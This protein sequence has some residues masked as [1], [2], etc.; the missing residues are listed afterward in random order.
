[1]KFVD[2]KNVYMNMSSM[3]NIFPRGDY[4]SN[5]TIYTGTDTDKKFA[6]QLT[7]IGN[8]ISNYIHTFG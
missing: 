1:M 4:K 2:A 7:V 3:I 8:I 5:F 6:G